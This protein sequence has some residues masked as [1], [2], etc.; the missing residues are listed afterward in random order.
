MSQGVELD[1]IHPEG[2]AWCHFCGAVSVCARECPAQA[3]ER[4]YLMLAWEQGHAD[5]M[6]MVR[7]RPSHPPAY[8]LGCEMAERALRSRV[9][10]GEVNRYEYDKILINGVD[11]TQRSVV[12]AAKTGRVICPG[13][14][15]TAEDGDLKI[16]VGAPDP[17]GDRIVVVID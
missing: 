9:R 6:R 3:H 10:H 11:V 5:G 7:Y 14:A 4:S 8:E 17:L 16:T 2:A 15:I 12:V 1:L 13:D